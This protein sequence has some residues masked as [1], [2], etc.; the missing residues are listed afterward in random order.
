MRQQSLREEL[1]PLG[2][3]DILLYSTTQGGSTL[4]NLTLPIPRPLHALANHIL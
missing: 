3:E 1:Q 4:T 2:S